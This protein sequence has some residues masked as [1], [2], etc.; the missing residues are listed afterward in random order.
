MRVI[1]ITGGV[2][3][4]KSRILEILK[5]EYHAQV[6]QADIVAREL[7]EP[8]QPGYQKLVET[9]G[10]SILSADGS[11]DRAV[12][13]RLIFS[14]GEALKAVNAI[15]HPLAWQAVKDRVAESRADLVAVEAAL[16]DERSREVCGELW[17]VDTS[18]ENR[19]RRLHKNRG[20]SREKSLS[21]MEN[22]PSRE[23]FLALADCVIDNNGTVSDVKSQIGQIL[24]RQESKRTDQ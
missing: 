18:E 24:K 9:F 7:E 14:D 15:I 4:G 1:G 11:I 17:F 19:I 16:F 2:G 12:L 6:I 23:A 5:K 3:A 13:A 20:Y 21:I 10:K 22:Q 8:G